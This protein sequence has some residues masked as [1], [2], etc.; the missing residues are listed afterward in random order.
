MKGVQDLRHGVLAPGL[1]AARLRAGLTQ[2]EVARRARIHFNTVSRAERGLPIH[3]A[4]VARLAGALRVSRETLLEPL[5]PRADR[6]DGE[7]AK[8]E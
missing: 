8:H 1:H 2:R 3:L 5:E 6:V 7:G 4:H